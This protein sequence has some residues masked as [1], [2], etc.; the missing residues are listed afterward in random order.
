MGMFVLSTAKDGS[1]HFSLHAANGEIILSS[2]MYTTK[3][4]AFD[5]ID[6]VR[7]NAPH[8]ERFERKINAAGQPMF[9]LKA[10]NH[11]VIGTSQGYSSEIARDIGIESVKQNAPG[12][13]I[14]DEAIG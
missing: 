3:A 1:F 12:A 11:Q 6:S 10:A 5:G 4:A 7:A 9:N 13:G 8:D 14:E 2:Q